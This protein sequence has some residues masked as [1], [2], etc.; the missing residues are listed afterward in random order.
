MI[1]GVVNENMNR[2][3]N[4]LRLFYT[5]PIVDMFLAFKPMFVEEDYGNKLM[6]FRPSDLTNREQL[7]AAMAEASRYDA[8]YAERT[9]RLSFPHTVNGMRFLLGHGVSPT[10]TWPGN[11]EAAKRR[12]SYI[13]SRFLQNAR[14]YDF[15]PVFLLLS[16]NTQELRERKG[17]DH[18]FLKS[19]VENPELDG[20]MYI[21]V[22]KALSEDNRKTYVPDFD[23]N[24][25]NRATHALTSRQPSHRGSSRPRSGTSDR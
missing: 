4:D 8:F 20:L 15:K 1:L 18:P 9:E 21:D 12:I 2:I 24:E 14:L 16:E 11:S 10:I 17:S 13:L 6:N 7:R 25:Y 3:M 23:F 5:Y 22:V 19:L